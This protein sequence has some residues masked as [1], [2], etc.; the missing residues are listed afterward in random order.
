MAR[1]VCSVL[2]VYVFIRKSTVVGFFFFLYF[3]VIFFLFFFIA[4]SSSVLYSSYLSCLA[5]AKIT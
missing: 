4:S 1:V 5:V 2:E 3:F